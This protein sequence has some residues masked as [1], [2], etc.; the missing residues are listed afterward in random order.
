[1]LRLLGVIAVALLATACD[2]QSLIDRY[3]PKEDVAFAKD[4]FQ[5]L[6]N[7]EFA[8]VE[9]NMNAG[10]KTPFLA[11]TLWQISELLPKEEPQDIIVIGAHTL[12]SSDSRKVYLVFQYKFSERWFLNN[13]SV[14]ERDGK[15]SIIGIN[16]QPLRDSLERINAFTLGGKGLFHYVVL[17]LAVIIPLGSVYA[18][19]ACIRTK[20]LKR[21]WLWIIFIIFGVTQ[22]TINWTTGAF[23]FKPISV[24]LLSLSVFGLDKYSPVLLSL[25]L[26]FGAI[27]FLLKRRR[28][29]PAAS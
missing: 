8:A 24:Q 29:A 10:L 25:S 26:P 5:K 27:T 16:V 3:A 2:S 13:L 6:Q 18:L 17:A 4:T 28:G 7:K 1:L 12:S 21:K 19:V 9:A 20:G 15:R 11:A 22:F 14:E 23:E